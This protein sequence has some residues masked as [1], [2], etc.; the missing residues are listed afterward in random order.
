MNF[1]ELLLNG[2]SFLALLREFAIDAADV[3]IMDENLI[4]VDNQNGRK[5]SHKENVLIKAKN[6]D[7]IFNFFGVL[8][9][10]LTDKLAVFEMQGFDKAEIQA[11]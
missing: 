10:N 6:K 1:K 7:N 4:H 2:K 9:F 8:H 3:E 11:A 5:Q